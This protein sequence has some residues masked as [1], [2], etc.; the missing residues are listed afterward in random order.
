MSARGSGEREALT[1]VAAAAAAATGLPDVIELAAEAALQALHAGSLSISRWERD[2]DEMRVLINVGE[3]GPGEE[4]FPEDET[5]PLAEYPKLRQLLQTATPYFTAVD[6]PDADPMSVALLRQLGKESDIGVPIVV[7]GEVWGEVWASTCPGAPRFRASDIRFLEALGGQ[8][9]GVIGRAELFSN[10]SR[11]AYEDELTG[12]AN[13]RRFEEQLERATE[14][15]RSHITPVTLLVCDVDEL[16][17]INDVRGHHAGDRALKRVADALLAAAAPYPGAVA[18]RLSGDEFAV[19]LEGNDMSAASDVAE[20]V[21]RVLSKDRDIPL[22]VSCGA[23]AAGPG[24]DRPDRLLRAADTAQYA[25]KQRGGAQF[26]TA[27]ATNTP[28]LPGGDRRRSRRRG[29]TERLDEASAQ[30]LEMLD[31]ELAA[32]STLDRL[33]V[34]L[35]TIAETINAA[36]WTI[37]FAAEGGTTIRSLANADDRD[38]RLRG[39][40]VGLSHEV[41]QLADYPQTAAIVE[42]GGGSFLVDIDDRD[43][44]PAERQ[45]LAELGFQGVLGAGAADSEGV[46]LIEVYADADTGDLS[47]AELRVQLLARAAA[48]HSAGSAAR[49]HQLNKR[50]RQLE[51]MDRLGTRLAGAIDEDAIAEAV[52]EEL[53]REFGCPFCGVIRKAADGHA[54]LAAARGADAVALKDSG[55]R[56]PAAL[57]LVG[58]AL[59]EGQLVVVGDVRPEPDYRK[60]N[61]TDMVRSELCAPLLCGDDMWGAI[62]LESGRLDAFDDDDARLVAAIARHAGA[63]LEASRHMAQLEAAYLDTAETL[64]A[65]LEAKDFY[66]VR[67]LA[68]ARLQGRGGRA[69]PG[70]GWRRATNAPVWGGLPRHRQARHPGGHPHEDR[71]ARPAGALPGGGARGDRRADDRVDR[72]P[73]AGQAAAAPLARALGWAR[74]PGWARRRGDPARGT[75]RVRL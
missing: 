12:L 37:S 29:A 2:Q 66:A 43:S 20:T 9:A 71:G 15:W 65:G 3:L 35:A 72:L 70:D 5:Y 56:Q 28:S 38:S 30:L 62:N 24:I 47:L 33:E 53:A 75:D 42:A 4:R 44:D 68:L 41:Y 10:V 60:T 64:T 58:R 11:L 49:K 7:E 14:R 74:L 59:R 23:A 13:R 32:R 25:A 6:D 48:G 21:L 26:C 61:T 34:V 46:F 69:C 54:E 1:R 39:I 17:A 31:G 36:A 51:L 40:R 50:T 67:A 16:K 8:L 22:G 18:A 45:L 57:G 27:E 73:G 55:W 19:L 52:V 63:A